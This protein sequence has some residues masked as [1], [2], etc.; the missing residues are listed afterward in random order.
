MLPKRI[1]LLLTIGALLLILG[2]SPRAQ[3]A[4]TNYFHI[5][6][7]ATFTIKKGA[8]VLSSV[9]INSPA[10]TETVTIFDNT[11]ASGTV[12]AVITV[13]ASTNPCF[14]YGVNF[15]TGLTVV[16]ATAAGD[17]TVAYQ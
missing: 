2:G 5:T 9:C 7:D 11:A 14:A 3:V 8:G 13:F 6:T 10:A 1:G 4:N 15:F 17:I 16:T 12:I